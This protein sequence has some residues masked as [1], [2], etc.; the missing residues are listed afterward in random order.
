MDKV[1]RVSSN[2]GFSE[3]WSNAAAPN[4]LNLCD[5]VL[6]AG[7]YDLSK[8]YVAFN[9][10]ISS[11]DPN[12][13]NATM[14][15]ETDGTDKYNV[16]VSALIRNCNIQN[17]RGLVE[18]IRR[19]DTLNCGLFGLLDNA[20]DRKNNLNTFACYEGP[21]GIGNK[22]SY[23]LDCVT[24]N[25]SPDGTTIDATNVSRL[26][27]RD[28]KVPLNELFGVANSEAYSTQVFGETRIHLETNFSKMKGEVLGG[29]EN[30]DLA[31]DAATAWGKFEDID[32][33]P[34]GDNA[35]SLAYPLQS[36]FTYDNWQLTF[37]FFVGQRIVTATATA[38][39]GT[40]MPAQQ[41]AIVKSIRYQNNNTA[42]PPTGG[43][44]V[45]MTL[46]RP[47]GTPWWNNDSGGNANLR[48]ITI[49]A[50]IDQTLALT[51]NRADLVLET[52]SAEADSSISFETY[53]TEEDTP[54]NNILNFSKAYS[55]EPEC[56]LFMVMACNSGQILPNR[57]LS[58]YRYAIDNVEQTGNRDIP[59]C[60][61]T[62]PDAAARHASSLQIDRL[63]RS[64]DNQAGLGF[65]NA[66]MRFYK[67][68]NTQ[69]LA[70]QSPVSVIAETCPA[71]RD[72][73]I[74]NLEIVSPAGLQDLKIYKQI[75]KTI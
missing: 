28:L 38:S 5:F 21:R 11:N 34:N 68:D 51:I 8:S 55:I 25:V 37:P 17:D 9:A 67:N 75:R 6:P 62:F 40:A 66:Q 56:P 14:Y 10:S 19:S 64:L 3:T 70:Y 20:E 60:T 23:F 27:S 52:T 59:V 35:G 50:K 36:T 12:P 58:S 41:E 16:P 74:L 73:K 45:F 53:T 61:G 65:R 7:K 49:K 15:L 57:S 48:G 44:K 72:D 29:S 4:S 46:E 71:T 43:G 22:T 13:C 30:T 18:S 69:A 32:T 24:D 54:A 26:I 47:D 31:F 2:Q 63:V 42:T 39:G 1:I 33:I